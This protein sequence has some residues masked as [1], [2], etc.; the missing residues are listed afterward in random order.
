MERY[1]P[2]YHSFKG[3]L[4]NFCSRFRISKIDWLVLNLLIEKKTSVK[5]KKKIAYKY[6]L[7]RMLAK[8]IPLQNTSLGQCSLFS[9]FFFFIC[10]H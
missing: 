8:L 1:H 5:E 7:D 2:N 4:L 9:F 6:E 3:S 10:I